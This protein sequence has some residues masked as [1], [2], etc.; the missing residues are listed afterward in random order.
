MEG[1]LKSNKVKA[2]SVDS[3][4]RALY[5]SLSHN[6]VVKTVR[7]SKVMFVDYD[8]DGKIVGVEVIRLKSAQIAVRKAFQDIQ[9][10][11][12]L[13]LESV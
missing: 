9:K 7:K 6:P 2:V 8:K 11:A 1:I 5:I 3:E 13:K 12:S 4:A 10:I